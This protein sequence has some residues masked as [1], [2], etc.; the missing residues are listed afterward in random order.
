[1]ATMDSIL[2]ANVN[3]NSVDLSAFR[4]RGSKFI[5]YQGW[6]DPLVNPQESINYYE[7]LVAAQ[8]NGTAAT[9]KA[10]SFYRLFMVPGMYHC[11]FGP[12]ANAFGNRFSGLVYELSNIHIS[13]HTRR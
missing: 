12:G 10:Q 9:R 13:E 7:R 2:A 11:A 8:G 4:D 5:M 1:M 6:A 3:A